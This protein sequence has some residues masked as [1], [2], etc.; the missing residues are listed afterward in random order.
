MAQ[1]HDMFVGQ[2]HGYEIM[3]DTTFYSEPSIT[4]AKLAEITG[5]SPDT[6]RDWRRRGVFEGLGTLQPNGRWLYDSFDVLIICVMREL[7]ASNVELFAARRISTLI[8]SRVVVWAIH[9]KGIMSAAGA[10][11]FSVAY[12]DDAAPA[13]WQVETLFHVNML[14]NT[15]DR[16]AACLLIDLQSMGRA[17]PA[18][19]DD[20]LKPI[21]TRIK[22]KADQREEGEVDG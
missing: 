4:P 13:G 16:G 12:P 21:A 20:L 14:N 8:T 15:P 17:L 10:C 5:V 3:R 18:Y 9:E 7:A 2:C 19:F 1:S 6:Q 22:E 11:R